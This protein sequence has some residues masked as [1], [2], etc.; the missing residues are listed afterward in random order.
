MRVE[1]GCLRGNLHLIRVLF[2][3]VVCPNM[4]NEKNTVSNPNFSLHD[5]KRP[6]SYFH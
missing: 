1:G 2:V 4:N 5:I 3:C 6:E